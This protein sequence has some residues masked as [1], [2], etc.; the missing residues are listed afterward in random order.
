V[1]LGTV[2]LLSAD[3]TAVPP[4]TASAPAIR[5]GPTQKELDDPQQALAEALKDKADLKKKLSE[6]EKDAVKARSLPHA[7]NDPAIPPGPTQKE[8]DDLKQALAGALKDKEDL[9]KK[10]AENERALL[11]AQAAKEQAAQQAQQA[12]G[13]ADAGEE[14]LQRREL[15]K[16]KRRLAHVAQHLEESGGGGSRSG[17]GDVTLSGGGGGGEMGLNELFEQATA[18]AQPG[19]IY[20]T[21]VY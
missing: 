9:R 21:I 10:L 11:P 19:T 8:V 14:E 3:E 7:I 12:L 18:H 4:T 13:H 1:Q 17:E 6:T 16:A 20:T 5:Q 15:Q 2:A